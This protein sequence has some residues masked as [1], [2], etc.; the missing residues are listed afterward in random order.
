MIPLYCS[1]EEAE[2]NPTMSLFEQKIALVHMASCVSLHKI[3]KKGS[4]ASTNGQMEKI[5]ACLCV[6]E[7]LANMRL[8]YLEPA[9]L[10]TIPRKTRILQR[11][12]VLHARYQS[13]FNHRRKPLS[14][15][16][17]HRSEAPSG[18]SCHHHKQHHRLEALHQME[19][20][21]TNWKHTYAEISMFVV[22]FGD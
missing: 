22:E 7:C 9:L 19:R 12:C 21:K 16:G 2:R 15:S 5:A 10:L 1:R 18:E 6:L 14:S 11:L 13:K 3:C 17:C 8:R 20:K 4:I